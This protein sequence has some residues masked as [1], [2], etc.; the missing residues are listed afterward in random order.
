MGLKLPSGWHQVSIEKFLKY[1]TICQ[2]KWEDPL[3]LEINLLSC[4]SGATTT[5]I[6]KLKTPEILKE[7]KRL[8]FLKELPQTKIHYAFKL[9]G[10]TYKVA[11]QMQDMT[12]GQFMNFSDILK[13][14]KPEDYIYQ[15]HELIATMCIKKEKGLFF[16]NGI[17]F[18]KYE[19]K[20]YKENADEFYKHMS[21]DI[22]YPYYVFFC[23]VMEKSLLDTRDSLLKKLEK[24]KKSNRKRR[25]GFLNIG[26]G[27]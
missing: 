18:S 20:G 1:N 13:G 16:E 21:I 26:G 7:I 4:F 22:A 5:E 3:D 25:W 15:M 14:V 17:S 19:Y 12:G 23:K 2:R 10:N 9:N 11:Y 6:E 24:L 27:I 8:D